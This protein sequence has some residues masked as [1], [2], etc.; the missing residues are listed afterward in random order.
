MEKDIVAGQIGAVGA[1][2]LEFKGGKLSLKVGVQHSGVGAD[3]VIWLES[4]AVLDA[5]AKAIPGQLDDAL[6][7]MLKGALK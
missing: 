3:V 6:L 2:D 7:G 5:L 1:Y 4:D